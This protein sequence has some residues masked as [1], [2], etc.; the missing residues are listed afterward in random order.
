MVDN[1]TNANAG[2]SFTF[3]KCWAHL[4]LF[5]GLLGFIDFLSQVLRVVNW[6]YFTEIG[7]LLASSIASYY[8]P[9][10]CA[11][12]E[13]NYPSRRTASKSRKITICI[14]ENYNRERRRRRRNNSN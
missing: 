4:G 14:K 7:L 11:C 1:G 13:N 9:Y 6:K 8:S 5:I 12:W 10:G 3:G 2:V